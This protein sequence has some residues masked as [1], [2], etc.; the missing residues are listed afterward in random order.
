[1]ANGLMGACHQTYLRKKSLFS[2]IDIS[3]SVAG[4]VAK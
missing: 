3:M 1:M 2:T 4:K